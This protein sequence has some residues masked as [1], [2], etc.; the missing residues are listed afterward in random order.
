[1]ASFAFFLWISFAGVKG[2]LLLKSCWLCFFYFK[3]IPSCMPYFV[4][5]VQGW[6]WMI[7]TD[8]DDGG[9]SIQVRCVSSVFV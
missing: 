5:W 1:M 4:W 6:L 2:R 9:R 7:M 3:Y 8:N